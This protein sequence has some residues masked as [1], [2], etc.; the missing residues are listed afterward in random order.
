EPT[1]EKIPRVFCFFYEPS[2]A[3]KK[4]LFFPSCEPKALC[5]CL[6]TGSEQSGAPAVP[7]RWDVKRAAPNN[8]AIVTRRPALR[9]IFSCE[10]APEEVALSG[11][12]CSA[13][14]L[15]GGRVEI[16]QGGGSA[17]KGG[18]T[19]EQQRSN[20]RSSRGAIEERKRSSRGEEEEQQRSSRRAAEEQQR[21]NRGA[22]EERKRL[23]CC[24]DG[25]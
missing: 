14:R 19:E 25:Y 6:A 18:A 20:N 15:G 11:A 9:R 13:Q 22:T 23:F 12:P 3:L 21:S 8:R 2:V 24:L 1:V 7:E 16:Q 17:N 10:S 5:G 4:S